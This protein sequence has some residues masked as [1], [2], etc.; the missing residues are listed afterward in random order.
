MCSTNHSSLGSG[1]AVLPSKNLNM[2]SG[3]AVFWLLLIRI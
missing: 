1:H 3:L 2:M